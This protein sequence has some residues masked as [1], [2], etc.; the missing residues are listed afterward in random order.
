LTDPNNGTAAGGMLIPDSLNPDN[1]TRFTARLDY[2]DTVIDTRPNLHV[3]TN[4]HATR[5]LVNAPH[6]VRPRDYPDD[7]WI[8]GVEVR[9]SP[10][11][12]TVLTFVSS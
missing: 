3:A 2:L 10:T 5:V 9:G 7:V 8:S 6:N 12:K 4:Q 1:Q 11:L